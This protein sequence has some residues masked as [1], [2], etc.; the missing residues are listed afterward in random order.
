MRGDDV[1]YAPG[2]S[3]TVKIGAT[4]QSYGSIHAYQELIR[5]AK[6]ALP[7]KLGHYGR[8]GQYQAAL[9]REFDPHLLAARTFV[10]AQ[11]TT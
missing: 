4:Q 10:H 7:I 5:K 9:H 6:H 1:L 3:L 11:R 8:T 2:Y